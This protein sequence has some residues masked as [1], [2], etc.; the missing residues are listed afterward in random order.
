V[1]VLVGCNKRATLKRELLEF[2]SQE[3]LRMF[4]STTTRYPNASVTI[5]LLFFMGI[6]SFQSA[7][8]EDNSL[9]DSEKAE[10][11][12]LLFDGASLRG[13]RNN[14]DAPVKAKIED[15]AINPHGSGG[16][17][18]VYEKPFGDFVLACDVK[19]SQ[20]DCNSGVFV[21]TG[22]LNDPVYSGIEVQV[23]SNTMPGR[24]SFGAIYDLMAP[25]KDATKG[26]GKWD[27]LEIRC[28][29]PH[30]TVNVN[31]EEV[32]SINCDEWDQPG[33]RPDGSSHKFGKAIKDFPREGFFGLQDHGHDVWYKN[34]KMRPL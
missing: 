14:N 30:I 23:L 34:I 5:A 2:N 16:Y 21:R 12:M 6:T 8:A 22:D 33:K 4:H 18:L 13:W 19:M 1:V 17:L 31:G 25:A 29:G 11:W 7:S 15:G 28:E 24:N 27:T 10:G 3:I 26:P 20:P 9:T 32:T